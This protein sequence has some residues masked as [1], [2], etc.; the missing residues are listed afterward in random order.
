M[1]KYIREMLQ[2]LIGK[3]DKNYIPPIPKDPASPA[4]VDLSPPPEAPTPGDLANQILSKNPQERTR[5][6][7]FQAQKNE[8]R[9]TS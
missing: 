6:L 7:D 8:E 2:D 9:E 1:R 5:Q 4:T 3:K